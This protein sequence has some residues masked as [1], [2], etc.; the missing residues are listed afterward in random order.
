[1]PILTL[2]LI[3]RVI[4]N[5]SLRSV[6]DVYTHKFLGVLAYHAKHLFLSLIEE[7]CPTRQILLGEPEEST[8]M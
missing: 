3:L 8:F 1:M 6:I 7:A 4:F 2:T 5:G